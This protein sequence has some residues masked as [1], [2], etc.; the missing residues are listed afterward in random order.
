M[1]IG[2]GNGCHPKTKNCFIEIPA[3]FSDKTKNQTI[4]ALFL[5]L[6]LKIKKKLKN[7]IKIKI[8]CKSATLFYVKFKMKFCVRLI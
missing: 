1:T 7:K 5:F 2:Y 4:F 6:L 3:S 8:N